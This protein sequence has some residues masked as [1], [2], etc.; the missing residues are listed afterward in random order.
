MKMGHHSTQEP[1][2]K[3]PLKTEEIFINNHFFIHSNVKK[4]W[5][6]AEPQ[7]H[8]LKPFTTKRRALQP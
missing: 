2:H 4:F 8:S 7:L 3:N 1:Q 6:L 5:N